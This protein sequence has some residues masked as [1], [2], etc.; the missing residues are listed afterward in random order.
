MK[1]LERA[2]ESAA[3]ATV[4]TGKICSHASQVSMPYGGEQYQPEQERVELETR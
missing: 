1:D 4:F 3:F 2:E